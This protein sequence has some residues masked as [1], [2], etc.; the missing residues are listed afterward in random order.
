MKIITNEA[1]DKPFKLA[2]PSKKIITD[3]QQW[4]YDIAPIIPTAK[5]AWDYH[6]LL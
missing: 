5:A 4:T 2:E 1:Y 3:Y 6:L